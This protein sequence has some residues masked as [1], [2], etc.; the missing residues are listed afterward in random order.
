MKKLLFICICII[1]LSSGLVVSADEEKQ[2]LKGLIKAETI[3]EWCRES[4]VAQNDS[5]ITVDTVKETIDGDLEGGAESAV[6]EMLSENASPKRIAKHLKQ[7][8]LYNASVNQSKVTAVSIY[9]PCRLAV[10]VENLKETY[11]ATKVVYFDGSFYLSYENEEATKCAYEALSKEYAGKVRID[12]PMRLQGDSPFCSWGIEHMGLDKEY[13]KAENGAQVTVAVIDSGLNASH[14]FFSN[15]T[16][17]DGYDFYDGDE[18][19]TDAD[20]HGTAVAGTIAEATPGNVSIMPVKVFGADDTTTS[21]TV[22]AGVKYAHEH[23]ADVINMSLGGTTTAYGVEQDE[24]FYSQFDEPIITGSG[25]EGDNMDEIPFSPACLKSTISVGAISNDSTWWG[26]SNYG[27]TLDFVAPGIFIKEPHVNSETGAF[28]YC[29]GTGTSFA[30]PHVS[31]AAALLLAQNPSLNKTQLKNALAKRCTDLGDPG[32]DIYYGYGMPDFHNE[33]TVT[34]INDLEVE[35]SDA[36]YT[37]STVIPTVTMLHNAYTLQKGEDF[38]VTATASN[39]ELGTGSIKIVGMGDYTGERDLSFSVERRNIADATIGDIPRAYCTGSAITPEPVINFNG[40]TLKK[41][42]D[43]TLSFENNIEP[44]TAKVIATGIGNF[45]GTIESDFTII[46]RSLK[47]ASISCSREYTYTGDAI[48]PSLKVSIENKV[49]VRDVDYTLTGENNINAGTATIYI[50]GAGIYTGSRSFN[51][52]IKKATI[53]RVEVTGEYTYTG[54]EIVPEDIRVYST[55]GLVPETDYDLSFSNNINVGYA[56]VVATGKGNHQSNASASYFIAPKEGAP[57][58]SLEQS[59]YTYDGNRKSPEMSVMLN[60]QTLA[61]DAYIVSWPVGDDWTCVGNHTVRID[62]IPEKTNYTGSAV[63]HFLIKGKPYNSITIKNKP[64]LSSKLK[65]TAKTAK[66]RKKKKT[67]LKVSKVLK[68]QGVNGAALIFKKLKG[69]KKISINSS[70]GKVLIKK[71]LKK[72][73]YKIRVQVRAQET[74]TYKGAT[75]T[76]TFKIKA[77]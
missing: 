39:V 66:V 25:N 71:G 55:N 18:D 61:C 75:R 1:L 42:K 32:K 73:T 53:R 54:E 41:D 43:Y 3:D 67:S 51:F 60:G 49:L 46:K 34:N 16:I 58:L 59:E 2:G 22:E 24:A 69:N 45:R 62:L 29:Y 19:V 65:V 47:D 27:S 56:S 52:V 21:L 36:E 76:V 37:G 10:D 20:G 70:S 63:A 72:G 8:G 44:G 26:L 57:V 4:V 33:L 7:T 13:E 31:A 77:K 74:N 23:G 50:T 9:G 15:T 12:T 48:L 11:G 30:A 28:N 64:L 35:L 5:F 6:E 68:I 17:V 38:T 14:P 40:M